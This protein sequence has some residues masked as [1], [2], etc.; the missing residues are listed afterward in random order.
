[1]FSSTS[2]AKWTMIGNNE[3][4]EIYIDVERIRK[5]DGYVYF[6]SLTDYLKPFTNLKLLS[7]KKYYQVD[8]DLFRYK[9]LQY[10]YHKESMGRDIGE[11]AEAEKKGWRYPQPK[12]FNEELVKLVCKLSKTLK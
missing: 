1:M 5:H 3:T 10:V 6:W 7:N 4:S 11:T 2:F 12:R 9:V 8:C